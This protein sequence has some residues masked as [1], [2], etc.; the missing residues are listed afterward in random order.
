LILFANMYWQTIA[1]TYINIHAYVSMYFKM[2]CTYH[3]YVCMK[4]H[5]EPAFTLPAQLILFN[6]INSD[7]KMFEYLLDLLF[8][9]IKISLW[10]ILLCLGWYLPKCHIFILIY[11]WKILLSRL[12]SLSQLRSSQIAD[13]Y[14]NIFALFFSYHL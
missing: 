4:S 9:T 12:T 7:I 5:S 8:F 2:T 3:D 13:L 6:L 1:Y 14:S 11:L 10:T